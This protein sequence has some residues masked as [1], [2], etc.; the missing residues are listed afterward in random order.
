M[1]NFLLRCS[2]CGRTYDGTATFRLRCE[3]ELNG[4]HGPALLKAQYER[5][6]IRFRAE[7]PGIFKF[8]DWL[9][10]GPY[11]LKAQSGH[12]GEPF[13]Y[14]S[15]NLGRRLGLRN[16]YIAFSGYWPEQGANLVTRAFKEF[17]VQ[18]S[19][20]CIFQAILGQSTTPFIVASAGNTA[21]SYNYYAH[22]TGLPLYLFVPVSGLG[23][24]LLP[25]ETDPILI[26]VE[27][28]Y[29][30]TIL[31]SDKV[32]QQCGLT[33]DG[34]VLNPGRRGGMGTVML[35]AVSHPEH[36]SQRLFDHYFQAVG[37][38][39][40][41][42][43]AWEAVQLLLAD[44]RFGDT[45]TRIHVAQNEPFVPIVR[46]WKEG[47][48]HPRPMPDSEAYAQIAAVS[49]MVLTTRRPAYN[50][51]GGLWDVLQESNG[52]AWGVSNE[53]IFNAAR[54]FFALEGVD[55]GPAAAVALN[56]LCQAVE[57]RIVKPHEHVLLHV[58]GGGREIQY[59][60]ANVVR[61][62]PALRIK[63]DELDVAVSAIGKPAPLPTSTIARALAKYESLA[64]AGVGA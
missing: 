58:T 44:G 26:A 35:N 2:S 14:R 15:V 43:G 54:M 21:N 11:Y 36:G 49:A 22:L 48:R 50:V 47:T 1:A 27:G 12:L 17:E 8:A 13:C 16:L 4:E 63:P 40:G 62:R 45:K 28:D 57:A 6:Q 41:A 25:F 32:A 9:P 38:G 52:C 51:V 18:A 3:A 61:A 33:R 7:L 56:A 37:S 30:D 34:G 20:V 5:R 64:V 53:R 29:T 19:I 55:V 46:A 42:I 59:S 24:L 31:L 23:N 60:E 39:S 10:S